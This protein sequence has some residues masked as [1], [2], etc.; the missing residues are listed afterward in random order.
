MRLDKAIC[1][2]TV[3]HAR[4]CMENAEQDG[5]IGTGQ[6]CLAAQLGSETPFACAQPQQQVANSR[7]LH[8]HVPNHTMHAAAVADSQYLGKSC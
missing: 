6:L 5:D 4:V 1:Y 2:W 8:Q 3:K 7:I